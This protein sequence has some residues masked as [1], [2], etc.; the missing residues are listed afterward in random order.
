MFSEISKAI[1]SVVKFSEKVANLAAL[2][3]WSNP[4]PDREDASS[5]GVIWWVR[6]TPLQ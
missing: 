1:C 3:P 6:I 2:I 4:E 5:R